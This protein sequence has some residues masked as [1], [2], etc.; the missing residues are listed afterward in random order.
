MGAA[1]IMTRVARR[2]S[3]LRMGI[4]MSAVSA[5]LAACDVEIPVPMTDV[6]VQ[7]DRDGSC[8]VAHSPVACAEIGERLSEMFPDHNCHVIIDAD[9]RT[10]FVPVGDALASI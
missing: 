7:I 5:L 2:F 1:L 8:F 9:R 10:F 3:F 6:H 4:S